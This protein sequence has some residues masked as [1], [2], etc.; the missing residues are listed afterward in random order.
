VKRLFLLKS[1]LTGLAGLALAAVVFRF[2]KGLGLSTGLHD[3]APWGF[4]NGIKIALVALSGGGFTLAGLVHVFHL[5]QFKPV[6]KATVLTAF[7][8]YTTF[9]IF[10]M[11]DIGLPAV[12]FPL[13]LK[14]RT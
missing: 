8:G 6:L 1:I 5:N 10:L 7:L 13:R 14:T 2:W 3:Y 9:V 11:L 12:V 4:W